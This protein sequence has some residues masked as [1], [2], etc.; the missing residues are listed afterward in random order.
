M[1]TAFIEA[2]LEGQAGIRK[3]KR[4]KKKEVPDSSVTTR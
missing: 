3:S 1:L 4:N 2:R